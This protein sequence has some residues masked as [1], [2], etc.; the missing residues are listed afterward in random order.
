MILHSQFGDIYQE[1]HFIEYLSPDIRIVKKLPNNLQSLDLEAIGSV[2]S[3]KHPLQILMRRVS[4]FLLC[5]FMFLSLLSLKVTDMDVMKEAK[6][7]FYMNHILPILLKNRVIHFVGF[8]NRLA[9]DPI[10]FELQ[11]NISSLL[12]LF[13]SLIIVSLISTFSGSRGFG[14]DVTSTL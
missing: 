1:E 4:I 10:P 6:L 11:V 9:F 8:G 12:C 2:V 13:L 14:A 3:F 7:D 5:L